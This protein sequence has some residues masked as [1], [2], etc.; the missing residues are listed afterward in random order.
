MVAGGIEY[1]VR[2]DVQKISHK[3]VYSYEKLPKQPP[4]VS[5]P[6]SPPS[7]VSDSDDEHPFMDEDELFPVSRS[8]LLEICKG[9]DPTKLPE[10]VQKFLE[11]T[12]G[13]G[14]VLSRDSLPEQPYQQHRVATKNPTDKNIGIG[15]DPRPAKESESEMV[16]FVTFPQDNTAT[17]VAGQ[18]NERSFD[19]PHQS[20][21]RGS[22]KPRKETN[23]L[24]I[25][26]SPRAQ[27][28]NQSVRPEKVWMQRAEG[29]GHA[30]NG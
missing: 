23:Q 19:P 10:M 1:P 30:S 21:Q 16:H 3:L 13:A 17:I 27:A 26:S 25:L 18:P 5:P 29:R 14:G 15:M 4:K 8:A 22:P 9:R 12:R 11:A 28:A 24:R 20:D 7:F 6:P 2:V